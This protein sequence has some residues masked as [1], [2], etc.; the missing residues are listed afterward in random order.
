MESQLF[1]T[2][3]VSL[4]PS[5]AYQHACSQMVH[6]SSVGESFTSSIAG[7]DKAVFS[8]GASNTQSILPNTTNLAFNGDVSGGINSLQ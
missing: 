2:E 6:E 5:K 8:D 4:T 1:L 3:Q 7:G